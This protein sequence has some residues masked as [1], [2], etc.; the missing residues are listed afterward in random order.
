MGDSV[1]SS[2]T[3][4]DCLR[5]RL[6]LPRTQWS[7]SC[8]NVT[9]NPK[10]DSD[11]SFVLNATAPGTP[12]RVYTKII[13]TMERK[14]TVLDGGI[15]KTVTI[16]GNSD[17]SSLVLDGASTSDGGGVSVPHYPYIYRIEVQGERQLNPMEKVNLSV[18]Y[19]Y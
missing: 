17:T 11:V 1:A 13:D 15:A 19:A 9:F 8:A 14:F 5:Q 12:Y 3:V 7:G 6:T 2:A 10:Q 18:Y 16:A 4:S